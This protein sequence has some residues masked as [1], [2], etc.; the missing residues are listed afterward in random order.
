GI[1]AAQEAM[2]TFGFGISAQG[3]QK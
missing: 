3:N 2:R 1:L